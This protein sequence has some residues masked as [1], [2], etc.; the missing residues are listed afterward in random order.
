MNTLLNETKK[1]NATA[2]THSGKFHAD[3]VF[4]SYPIVHALRKKHV[5]VLN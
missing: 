1:K 5:P 2:F 3:D 4:S